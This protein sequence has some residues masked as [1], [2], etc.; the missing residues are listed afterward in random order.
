MTRGAEDVK[1]LA[2]LLDERQRKGEGKD[3]H[4]LVAHLPRVERLIRA[5]LLPGDRALD[6]RPGRTLVLERRAR[7]QRLDAPRLRHLLPA[8]REEQHGQC[9]QGNRKD[10]VCRQRPAASG[11]RRFALR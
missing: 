10:P 9:G 4:F 3:A 1:P 5:E 7:L 8:S 6:Q 2:S 11:Q